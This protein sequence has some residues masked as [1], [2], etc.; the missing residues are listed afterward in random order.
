MS[1]NDT[2]FERRVGIKM[3]TPEAEEDASCLRSPLP[4]VVALSILSLW[5]LGLFALYLWG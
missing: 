3:N 4:R 2:G 1:D 5:V